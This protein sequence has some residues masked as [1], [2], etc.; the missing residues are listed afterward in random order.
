[1]G[2]AV[3]VLVAGFAGKWLLQDAKAPVV[4]GGP[5]EG[6][7]RV[8]LNTATLTELESIPGVGQSLAR[9]IVAHRPYTAVDQLV[10][11]R[12]IGESAV[13]TLRPFVKTD[14]D[15]EKLIK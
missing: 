3:A 13:K 6:S 8:N 9:Q 2:V 15:T 4:D 12:G 5:V 11:I 7:L 1:M 10:A 14:G